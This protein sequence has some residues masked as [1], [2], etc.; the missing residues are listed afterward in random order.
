MKRYAIVG[1]TAVLLG[2]CAVPVP[3]QVAAWVIDGVSYVATQKS[4]TDHGI[5]IVAQQDCALWRGVTEGEICRLHDDPTVVIALAETGAHEVPPDP[6]T[7]AETAEDADAAVRALADFETAAGGDVDA[8]TEPSPVPLTEAPVEVAAG[9][10]AEVEDEYEDT[11]PLER[12]AR[13]PVP[14]SAADVV[15]DETA[16][17]EVAEHEGAEDG[18]AEHRAAAEV[19]A[20]PAAASPVAEPARPGE[21]LPGRYL[22]LASFRVAGNAHGLR[23]E[24]GNLGAAILAA[25]IGS[26]TVYRVAV[27][28]YSPEVEGTLRDRLAREGFEDPWAIRVRPGEW[29]LAGVE[30]VFRRTEVASLR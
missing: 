18:V 21:P 2:G 10:A 11:Q 1:A 12:A 27:G 22:V 9:D 5:S 23:D 24:V 4:V 17:D 3:L 14:A 26:R 19:A 29:T 16:A 15:A 20:M 30:H 6:V 7:D 25:R 8:G 28:P 13:E